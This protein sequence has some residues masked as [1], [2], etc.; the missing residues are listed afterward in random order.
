MGLS[1]YIHLPWCVHKCPYCDF[2]SYAATD[3]PQH[4]Y[5]ETLIRELAHARDS[6]PWAGRKIATVFFGGGTPS[7]FGAASF[8]RVLAQLDA[9]FGIAPGAEITIEANPGTLEGSAAEQLRAFRS[10]GI[11]RI[12][13][14]G[15][16]FNARHL[17]TLG[18]IHSAADTLQALEASSQAGFERVSCDL[19]FAVPGQ[20]LSEWQSDLRT[21]IDSG[22]G[23]VSAYNLTYEPGTAMTGMKEAGLIEAVGDELEMEMFHCA[24]ELLG[25]AGYRHYEISNYALPDHQSRHNLAYW[26]WQDYLGL[27][28]GAHGFAASDHTTANEADNANDASWGTR[29]ANLRVPELYMSAAD[30]C[31]A[32]STET[33]SREMAVA[34]YLMMGLRLIDGV[35]L[36]D[37]ERRFGTTLERSVPAAAEL[38]R[39]AMLV[40]D[41]DRLRLSSRGLELADEVIARLVA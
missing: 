15:Q 32:A 22:P 13:L 37:F 9:A 20:T 8:E 3:F 35:D 1:V 7:L 4:R 11:N 39:S 36:H 10:A 21:L 24:A 41:A 17:E 27:G 26:N 30:G 28:A 23:H 12:S 33:L 5:T 40:N 38:C 25:N 6:S 2:N 19:M 14:G 16:S 31:W 29:Y 34:E 18:R